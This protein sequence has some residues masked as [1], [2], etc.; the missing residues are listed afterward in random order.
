VQVGILPNR[1]ADCST[2]SIVGAVVVITI[3][4]DSRSQ[5]LYKWQPFGF[6]LSDNYCSSI[7]WRGLH[8]LNNHCS[9]ERGRGVGV[10]RDG[11]DLHGDSGGGKC[12]FCR[13]GAPNPVDRQIASG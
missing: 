4:Q 8:E 7:P 1:G 6:K 3:S 10:A 12:D 2:G 9:A 5:Q 11:I 13:D